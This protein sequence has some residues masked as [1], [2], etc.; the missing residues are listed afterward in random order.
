MNVHR[1]FWPKTAEGERGD[2]VSGTQIFEPMAD[3]VKGLEALLPE[4]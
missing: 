1:I 3:T 2:A 4:G